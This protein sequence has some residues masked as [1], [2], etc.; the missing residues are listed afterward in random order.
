MRNRVAMID[1]WSRGNAAAF[2]PDDAFVRMTEH[3]HRHL[4]W[5]ACSR[6]VRSILRALGVQPPASVIDVGCGWGVNASP[7]SAPGTQPAESPR[8]R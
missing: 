6:L 7:W 2:L 3:M 4:W 5:R 1:T 8:A